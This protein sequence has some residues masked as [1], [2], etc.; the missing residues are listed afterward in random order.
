MINLPSKYVVSLD[1]APHHSVEEYNVPTKFAAKSDMVSSFQRR[2]QGAQV[3]AGYDYEER[4]LVRNG[5]SRKAIGKFLQNRPG[6]KVHI[7]SV[8]RLSPYKVNPGVC[9]EL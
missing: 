3:C 8:V 4:T 7:H 2:I 6:A 9:V 5:T 1:N